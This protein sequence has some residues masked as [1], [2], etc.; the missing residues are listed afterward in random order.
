M[1]GVSKIRKYCG[2]HKYEL[3]PHVYAVAEEMYRNM[4]STH[5]AQCVLVSG[6]SGAGK[7]ENAKKILSYISAVSSSADDGDRLK[8]QLLKS[9]PV[10]EA[11]GNA[12]TVRNN[13][14]SRFGKYMEIQFTLAGAPV[15]GRVTNYLLEKPRVVSPGEGER[16]FHIFYQL[17]AGVQHPDAGAR[18]AGL[19]IE[20]GTGDFQYLGLSTDTQIKG[21]S[22]SDEFLEMKD[23]MADIGLSPDDVDAM[24]S[25]TAAVLH[26]GNVA[27]LKPKGGGSGK[28]VRTAIAG[29]PGM[30]ALEKAASLLGIEGAQALL[31]KALIN[32]T[33]QAGM[34][35]MVK[36]LNREEA[37]YTRDAFAKAL[38]SRNFSMLVQ[39]INAQIQAPGDGDHLLKIG[40]LDIYGFEIFETNSFEQLCINYCNEKLQQLFIELTLKAEQDEYK[41]EGIEWT[42]VK[43]FNNK[44]V[45]DLIEAK[46][47][48]GIIAFLDEESIFPSAS[49]ASLLN[50][51]KKNLAKHKHFDFKTQDKK[52][53]G[54]DFIVKHYAGDVTYS[55]NGFLE[56][57]RDTLFRDLIDAAGASTSS[58]VRSLFPEAQMSASKKR[59]PTAATQFKKSMLDLIKTLMKCEPHYI[60]CIKPNDDKRAGKYDVDRVLH[61]AQYLGLLENVKVRRAGFAFRQ[62]FEQFVKRYK[63]LCPQTWPSGSGDLKVSVLFLWRCLVL[64]NLFV[65]S[66][67][68]APSPPLFPFLTPSPLLLLNPNPIPFNPRTTRRPFSTFKASCPARSS[69]ARPKSSCASPSPCLGSKSFASASCTTLSR[70]CSR[71][72]ARTKRANSSWN[73]AK[74]RCLCSVATNVGAAACTC[75]F[76]AT[77]CTPEM[78]SACK[79]SCTS[80]VKKKYFLLRSCPRSTPSL[81]QR[82]A[83][84]CSRK[85]RCTISRRKNSSCS[86][87]CP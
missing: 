67:F 47:P 2:R 62:T 37:L 64:Y 36:P 25:L 59:P 8:E 4:L 66:G 42:P 75:T 69:L 41:A 9:N 65:Y 22:D 17:C 46:R 12:T 68:S 52:H 73:C 61:Q 81:S 82:T 48:A 19:G 87:E 40:I 56:K 7:T 20:G 13:N 86:A 58:Y 33:V 39:H 24:F 78:S 23:A 74:S 80:L 53:S 83:C 55:I 34:D 16:N 1:Y 10:L 51:L 84:S 45:C 5:L 32:R 43:F 44:I 85:R 29:G 49:D 21:M 50:K 57:N 38:Y 79:R 71:R 70:W 72:T 27:F 35:T 15:G 28:D 63:M 14:S 60:R 31:G 6:E 11:F 26:L 54:N 18:L 76:W 77:I 30:A 3:Q